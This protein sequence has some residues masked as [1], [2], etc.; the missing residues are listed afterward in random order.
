MSGQWQCAS[1]EWQSWWSSSWQT[2]PPWLAALGAERDAQ[3]F[4][5]PG[6][7][8][9]RCRFSVIPVPSRR[10]K[11]TTPAGA[12]VASPTCRGPLWLVPTE[13][14]HLHLTQW[15]VL[16]R[17]KTLPLPKPVSTD[18][19]GTHAG[20][21]STCTAVPPSSP[22]LPSAGNSRTLC[23]VGVVPQ[24]VAH[25]APVSR[26]GSSFAFSSSSDESC[27]ED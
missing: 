19:S 4:T 2:T 27:L 21:L 16:A 3:S 13:Q 7:S 10:R 5:W 26:F 25:S 12:H 23:G 22:Q 14:E 1:P 6:F 17:S 11:R 8:Q 20:W 15:L 24:A 9:D 18:E